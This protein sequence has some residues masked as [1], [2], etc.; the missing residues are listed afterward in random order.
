MSS[1]ETTLQ[2]RWRQ[3]YTRLKQVRSEQEVTW[4]R[5]AVRL[6]VEAHIGPEIRPWIFLR[7]RPV[8]YGVTLEAGPPCP[9][10]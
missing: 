4:D 7:P 2:T 10:C 1:L 9:G 8:E 6:Y 5:V 3:L